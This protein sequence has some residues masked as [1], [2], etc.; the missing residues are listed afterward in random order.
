ML[1][2]CSRRRISLSTFISMSEEEDVSSCSVGSSCRGLSMAAFVQYNHRLTQA[3]LSMEEK[4][5]TASSVLRGFRVILDYL[6]WIL[7][8]IMQFIPQPDQEA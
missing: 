4:L 5:L 6:G 2:T 7:R 1:L 3:L 8:V